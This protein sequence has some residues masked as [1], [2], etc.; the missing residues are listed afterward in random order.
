MFGGACVT[1]WRKVR[2]GSSSPLLVCSPFR[3]ASAHVPGIAIGMSAALMSVITVWLSDMKMGYCKTGWWL[4]QKY[5]CLEL[6]DEGEGC[7]EWSN[8]GGVEPFRWFAYILF[9]VSGYTQLSQWFYREDLVQSRG[10]VLI[11]QATFS[12]SA[13]FIV[14]SFAPYAA[15][16]GISEIKCILGGFIIKGFLGFETFLI[17]A[18]TLVRGSG[19]LGAGSSS[20][21]LSL[22]LSLPGCLSAGRG[23]RCTWPALRAM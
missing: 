20:R 8:W 3:W 23:R 19:A 4:S 9:A 17:K 11:G 21:S 1:R 14:R 15:G 2:A 7:A 5:C 6:G 12:F 16:S 13:A 22:W 10:F 18:L